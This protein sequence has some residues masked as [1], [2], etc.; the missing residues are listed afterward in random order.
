MV[1][2]MLVDSGRV[3]LGDKARDAGELV[4]KPTGYAK[5]QPHVNGHV[6]IMHIV[7][8]SELRK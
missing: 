5:E 1:P 7:P 3:E 4:G 2:S 6:H 8:S